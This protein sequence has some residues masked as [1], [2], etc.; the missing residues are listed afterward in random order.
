MKN[1]LKLFLIAAYVIGAIGG[2]GYALHIHQ[3]VVAACI[4]ILAG[5]GW[6]TFHHIV[7][8]LND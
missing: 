5:M 4:A 1:F 2:F 6:P 3:P 7:R 8:H